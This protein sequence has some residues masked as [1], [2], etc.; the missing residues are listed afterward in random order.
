MATGT[1]RHVPALVTAATSMNLG[2]ATNGKPVCSSFTSAQKTQKCPVLLMDSVHLVHMSRVCFSVNTLPWS[3]KCASA[4]S[5]ISLRTYLDQKEARISRG[6]RRRKGARR[7][8]G[9][10]KERGFALQTPS[11]QQ[12]VSAVGRCA[13]LQPVSSCTRLSSASSSA[14]SRGARASHVVTLRPRRTRAAQKPLES[15]INV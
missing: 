13:H 3:S 8:N 11:A 4:P 2:A 1:K 9:R 10:R 14:S 7:G 12:R 5:A 15:S 6:S